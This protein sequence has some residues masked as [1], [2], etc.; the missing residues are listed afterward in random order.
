MFPKIAVFVLVV[1]SAN[2]QQSSYAGSFR[3]QGYKDRLIQ[4]NIPIGNSYGGPEPIGPSFP[5]NPAGTIRGPNQQHPFWNP[6]HGFFNF[7]R[8]QRSADESPVPPK[9]AD[10]AIDQMGESLEALIRNIRHRPQSKFN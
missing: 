9:T 6:N 7:I 1:I 3:G 5:Q 8:R 4:N 10:D 2:A